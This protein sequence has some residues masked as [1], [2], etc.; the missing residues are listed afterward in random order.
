MRLPAD[1]DAD[2]DV[3]LKP[4]LLLQALM[5]TISLRVLQ[6]DTLWFKTRTD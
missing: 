2:A 1:A 6:G 3:M 5:T 4:T